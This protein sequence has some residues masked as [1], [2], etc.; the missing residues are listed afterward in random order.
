MHK[1]IYKF[2]IDVVTVRFDVVKSFFFYVVAAWNLLL[3][4][5]LAIFTY[6]LLLKQHLIRLI[7]AHWT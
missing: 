4:L 2:C 1:I 5:K 3:S 7:A 6:L